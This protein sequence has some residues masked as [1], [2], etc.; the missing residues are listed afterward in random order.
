[1]RM[2]IHHD[3]H[4]QNY[5]LSLSLSLSITKGNIKL[6]KST[7]LNM[8]IWGD[9]SFFYHFDSFSPAVQAVV[10]LVKDRQ[11]GTT[12]NTIVVVVGITPNVRK[13]KVN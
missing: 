12:G 10:H 5:S 4:N 7:P 13:R 6:S 2:K 11:P 3:D 1:M 8:R 9:S